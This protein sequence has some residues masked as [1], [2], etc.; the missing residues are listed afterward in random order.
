[1][2]EIGVSVRL[3]LNEEKY[4][5]KDFNILANRFLT[6]IACLNVILG[7]WLYLLHDLLAESLNKS[8]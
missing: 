3:S 5:S 7:L 1:M 6:N 4:S 2:G 8:S